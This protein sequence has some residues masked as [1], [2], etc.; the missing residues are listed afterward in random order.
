MLRSTDTSIPRAHGVL[1]HPYSFVRKDL[2]LY[3]LAPPFATEKVEHNG[4]LLFLRLHCF[5]WTFFLTCY[6]VKL[7]EEEAKRVREVSD[8]RRK[9]K[10]VVEALQ[11]K[12]SLLLGR[13][14]DGL[15]TLKDN[16]K[17]AVRTVH[18]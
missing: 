11:V 5:H 9:S 14:L 3:R 7:A 1:R 6:H 15:S 12:R 18:S 13:L 17:I 16:W 8:A 10:A 4:R 2:C